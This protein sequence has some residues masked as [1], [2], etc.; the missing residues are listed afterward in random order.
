MSPSCSVQYP[1]RGTSAPP[2]LP[3]VRGGGWSEF[4]VRSA[5]GLAGRMMLQ[6]FM[7]LESRPCE[8]RHKSNASD[9]RTSFAEFARPAQG[10][11]PVHV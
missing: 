10:D 9:V 3:C 2:R 4:G 6:F 7:L 11:M 1:N 8:T 5:S